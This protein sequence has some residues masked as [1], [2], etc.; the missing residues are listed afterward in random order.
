METINN[1]IVLQRADPFVYKHSDGYYYFTGSYPSYDRIILR[2][3]KHLNDLQ[4]AE[5]HAVW[6]K[7]S[8]GPQSDLIW[9]PELHRIDGKWY[10][11]YAASPDDKIVD[12][13]F[14]H[15]M[16]VLE[17]DSDNPIEGEWKEKGQIDPGW[18][19]FALDATTFEH[20]GVQYYVWS[21]QDLDITGHSNIYIAEMENPW[22]L[23]GPPVMLTKPELS[24][25]IRGFWV[26]EGPAV[27][28]RN[29]KVFIT[30][31][32]SATGVDYCMGML[33][34]DEDADLLN[35]E[36]WTKR[37]EPVFESY[38]PNE[39]YG[40]GHN[41]F[42]VSEDGNTDILIYHARNYTK[43]EGDPLYDPNRH[44]RAQVI[45][46]NEDGTPHFGVPAKDDRWTPDTPKILTKEDENE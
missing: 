21:Q 26:N 42:T 23:A 16:Y 25:E 12:D 18:S 33:T 46:W 15:R 7:H 44:A 45:T 27:L 1:P 28:I 19:T 14:N 30:Y 5:E 6:H 10:I 36:S 13:T 17:N 32:A 22:T 29:G 9:A 8:E 43:I 40:P 39:Q 24:W 3:A 11:Y 2:R 41:S 34:A 35:T 37:Q 4:D 38:T 31:S 20:D